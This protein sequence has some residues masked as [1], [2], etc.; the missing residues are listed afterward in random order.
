MRDGGVLVTVSG[1]AVPALREAAA[2]R[3]RV[4]G[5]LVEPD[6]VGMEALAAM[7]LRPH[8]EA[9]FPLE[10]AAEAHRLGEQGRTCGK[11]VLRV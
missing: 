11:L 9:T 1:S 8:V 3:V 2:D 5:I 10:Q 6:R 7:G 4:E